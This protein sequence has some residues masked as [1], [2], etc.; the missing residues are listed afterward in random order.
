M[1]ALHALRLAAAEQQD[2][3]LK[4]LLTWA[5]LHIGDQYERICELEDELKQ[6]DTENQRRAN[7]LNAIR[8][9]LG[10]LGEVIL[11]ENFSWPSD[12]LAKDLSSW[13]NALAAYGYKPDGTVKKTK[14]KEKSA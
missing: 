12:A 1:S 11:K 9:A 6:A 3:D 2:G 13:R 14:Q 7:A 5:E 4:R 10:E 8:A